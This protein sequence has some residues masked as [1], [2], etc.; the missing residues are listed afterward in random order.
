MHNNTQREINKHHAHLSK[1]VSSVV[2][3]DFFKNRE[4]PSLDEGLKAILVVPFSM[5]PFDSPEDE[6]VYKQFT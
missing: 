4:P 3:H 6:K 1:K 2:I 5:G